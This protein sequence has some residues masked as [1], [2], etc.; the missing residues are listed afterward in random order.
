MDTPVQQSP[1]TLKIKTKRA[2]VIKTEEE[3]ELK[4]EQVRRRNALATVNYAKH[5]APKI[6]NQKKTV[7][8][9][10]D[11]IIQQEKDLKEGK[12]KKEIINKLAEIMFITLATLLLLAPT[13]TAITYNAANYIA[14][15]PSSTNEL[16][17]VDQAT[18][19]PLQSTYIGHPV[20][21]LVRLTE[22]FQ[23][24]FNIRIDECKLNG[25]V[26]YT[27]KSGPTTNLFQPFIE[28]SEGRAGIVL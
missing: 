18:N 24:E 27:D 19:N 6:A 12:L 22:K 15:T 11:V 7:E 8:D 21:L 9:L 4:R 16:L 23:N 1:V 17:I 14:D 20:K 26:I 5:M 25:N 2:N 28:S 10:T 3:K 13:T